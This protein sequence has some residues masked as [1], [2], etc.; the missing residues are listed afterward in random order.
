MDKK[1]RLI[2]AIKEEKNH[3]ENNHLDTEEHEVVL[4]YLING[5]SNK[6]P[7]KYEL[8]DAAMNDFDCLC[9]DYGITE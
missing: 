8:L 2:E 7:Y 9:S 6:D 4:S 3:F 1:Q 5:K